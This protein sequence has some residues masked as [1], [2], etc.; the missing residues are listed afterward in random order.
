MVSK[1][2]QQMLAR[3]DGAGEGSRSK[4]SKA[5]SKKAQHKKPAKRD[6]SA[7]AVAQAAVAA[8]QQRG[9]EQNVRLL[10]Y[11]ADVRPGAKPKRKQRH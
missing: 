9:A 11:R 5:A 3:M 1:I 7:L 2:A 6:K 4:S 8:Q 10:T